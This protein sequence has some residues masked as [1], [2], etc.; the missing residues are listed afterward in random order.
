MTPSLKPA[1]S[2]QQQINLL[3]TR[4]MIIPDES[5]AA[6]FLS[7]NHYYRLNVYFHKMMDYQD[8]FPT[9]VNFDLVIAA[10]DNDSWIRHQILI[11]LEPIEITAR[12][13]IAHFMGIKYGPDAFYQTQLYKSNPA[14]YRELTNAFNGELSRNKSDPVIKHHVKSYG[15]LFPI[16]VVVEFLSFN[17][18]SK[19]FKIL[20][21]SD[22]KTI[23][24]NAFGL[25]SA[26]LGEWLHALSV[27]RNICAHYGYLYKRIYAVTP[28]MADFF[29]WDKKENYSLFALMLIVRRLSDANTWAAFYNSLLARLQ[30]NTHLNL[31]DYGFPSDWKNFL[32]P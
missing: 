19:Y 11:L 12:T 2:I 10:Y 13:H 23:A 24:V 22:Q 21:A 1:L 6:V 20:S 27:L 4:G 3:K 30:L 17:K 15:G 7:K 5:K 14:Y 16:W 28:K 26:L 9:N 29:H 25:D 18:L 31:S 32:S 8:H